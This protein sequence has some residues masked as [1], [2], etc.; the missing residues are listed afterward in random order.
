[1]ERNLYLLGDIPGAHELM[2]RV[3]DKLQLDRLRADSHFTIEHIRW[4]L[5]KLEELQ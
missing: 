3:M 4:I 1:M 2:N 5:E